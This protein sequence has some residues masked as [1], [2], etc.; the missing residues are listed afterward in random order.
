MLGARGVRV[1]VSRILYVPYIQRFPLPIS[2]LLFFVP[3]TRCRVKNNT[4]LHGV[5]CSRSHGYKTNLPG[6]LL[7]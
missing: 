1:T 3:Q 7:P 4:L 5:T 6:T 2:A